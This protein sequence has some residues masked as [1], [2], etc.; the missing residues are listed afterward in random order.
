MNA[1]DAAQKLAEAKNNISK[2]KAEQKSLNDSIKK[3]GKV[4]EV[5]AEKLA[6]I[7]GELK[8]LSKTEKMYTAQIQLATQNDKKYGDSIIEL[9]GQLAQLKLEYRSLSKQERESA[10]G[11]EML[12]SIQ[13]LDHEVKQLDVSLGDNQRLV[14]DYTSF[15]FGVNGQVL[16]LANLF[17]GGFRKGLETVGAQLK[18]FGK[19]ILTTPLGWFAAAAAAVTAILGK[20]KNA[21]KTNDEAGTALAAAMAR[22]QPIMDAINKVFSNLAE[23]VAKFVN[24][25]TKAVTFILEKMV[26]G[27]DQAANAARRL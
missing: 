11:K 19:A 25:A 10:A 26:P 24:A 6:Q 27:Y 12:K 16:K 15:L 1:G 21:F 23:G 18:A 8:D 14:G 4:T 3:N 7:N 9:G 2:L 17:Q 13:A 20:L 22:L 5:Q